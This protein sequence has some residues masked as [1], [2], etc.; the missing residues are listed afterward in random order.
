MKFR[1]NILEFPLYGGLVL[2]WLLIIVWL[3][4]SFLVRPAS[5]QLPGPTAILESKEPS[6]ERTARPLAQWIE[7]VK[8]RLVEA[9]A[10]VTKANEA[11]QEPSAAIVQ[12]VDLLDRLELTLGQI[13]SAEAEAEATTLKRD[14]AKTN[15]DGFLLQ[16]LP[17]SEATSFLLLDATRDQ[18]DEAKGR[19]KRLKVRE[20][21]ALQELENAR[22]EFKELESA[23]RI[24]KESL[25]ESDGDAQRIPLNQKHVV[26]ALAAEVAEA[27]VRRRE[28][29]LLTARLAR[30]SQEFNL[31]QLEEKAQVLTANARFDQVEL[32]E[33]LQ[34]L[35][36]QATELKN[37]S[38]GCERKRYS[39]QVSGRAMDAYAA[40]AR[41]IDR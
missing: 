9:E 4:A 24:A 19:L 1:S 25:D 35:D 17:E 40:A 34:K 20:K 39:S 16:G 30:E 36:E 7:G 12:Q 18:I 26:A 32:N 37:D 14:E 10:L 38:V 21:G 22:K 13:A 23:R 33:Q 29:E 2:L 5:A 6:K 31:K 41:C 27:N 8:Q 3:D 11:E 28:A 15:L